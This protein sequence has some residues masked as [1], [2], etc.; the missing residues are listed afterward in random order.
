MGS[1]SEAFS[2]G[3]KKTSFKTLILSFSFFAL[4]F[5][6]LQ[7]YVYSNI[8][9]KALP[10]IWT[11]MADVQEH[12]KK[13]AS[14]ADDFAKEASTG[15]MANMKASFGAIASVCGSCHKAFRVNG[16]QHG[17]CVMVQ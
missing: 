2:H 15:K 9:T 13:V 12:L 1:L 5:L 11:H 3:F 17:R 7:Q 6:A 10:A 14:A 4:S 16:V 8:Y